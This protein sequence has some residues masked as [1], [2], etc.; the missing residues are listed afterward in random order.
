MQGK[1]E[2]TGNDKLGQ[3]GPYT[4]IKV[5]GAWFTVNGKTADYTGKEVKFEVQDKGKYKVGKNVEFV[6]AQ[7]GGSGG[8]KPQGASTGAVPIIEWMAAMKEFHKLALELEPDGEDVAEGD[9]PEGA[10][11]LKAIVVD[12]SQARAAILNTCMIALSKRRIDM[13][14]DTPF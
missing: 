8:A 6:E 3:Y 4:S 13:I 7:A 11:T 2:A 5:G 12:R 1:V 9:G 10:H 14:D